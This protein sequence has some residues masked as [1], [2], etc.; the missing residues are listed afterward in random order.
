MYDGLLCWMLGCGVFFASFL[1]GCSEDCRFF[2]KSNQ[3][4]LENK[5]E[6]GMKLLKRWGNLRIVVFREFSFEFNF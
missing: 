1:M 2:G 4:K 3:I 5:N 6:I